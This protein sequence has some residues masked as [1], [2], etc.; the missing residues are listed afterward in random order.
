MRRLALIITSLALLGISPALAKDGALK[1]LS[2][3]DESR[4]WEAVG[5]LDL[6]GNS[7]CTG[8]LIAPN[9]V[10]TAAHCLFSK[11]T[12]KMIDAAQ[13]RFLAGWRNGRAS[14]YRGAR[15][16]LA[17]SDY[18]YEGRD[19]VDRVA[20]DIA[21]VELDQPIR[22]PSIQ[23]FALDT[24]PLR[25]EEV[26]VVSYAHDR[27]DAPSLQEVCEVLNREAGVAAAVLRGRFWFVR[28]AG[29][30]DARWRAAYRFGRLGQS[31]DGQSQGLAGDAGRCGRRPARRSWRPFRAG[32]GA[33][34]PPKRREIPAPLIARL[35]F[36]ENTPRGAFHRRPRSP[37]ARLLKPR[38]SLPKF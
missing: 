31:R 28:G 33:V 24:A 11:D 35:L 2:T 3:G 22:L 6:G 38:Q 29:L 9:L 36:G 30:C 32:R 17:H 21:L 13:I 27:S 19:K 34:R 25:G 1:R 37:M 16:A 15:R 23:P 12:G 7:F 5:R 4:G 18:R 8:A 10:L 14:A 20:W 26:G